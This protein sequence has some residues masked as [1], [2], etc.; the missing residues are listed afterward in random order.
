MRSNSPWPVHPIVFAIYFVLFLYAQNLG[1]VALA[2]VV[3]V[4][5]VAAAAAGLA[6]LVS[7]LIWRDLRRGAL[8]VSVLV[9]IFFGYR[10][11][12]NALTGLPIPTTLQQLGWLALLVGSVV[13]AWRIRD[14]LAGLT[15]ALDLVSGILVLVTLVSIVPHVLG[16]AS[17]APLPASPLPI[18]AGAAQPGPQRDVWYLIFDRYASDRQLGAAYGIEGR[19]ADWLETRGFYVARDSQ[20]NYV[21]TSLSIASS[22]NLTYLDDLAARMGPDSNDHGPV[23]ELMQD[24]VLGRFLQSQ[25]Y[26]FV[27]VGSPYGPTKV[28]AH[29]DQ[30]PRLDSASGFAGAIFDES[31]LPAL[32]RR[33]GL[34]TAT[35]VRERYYETARF[36]QATL[37]GLVEAPG[38]KLVFAHFLLPHPPYVFA[39]DGS[40]VPEED[41]G[42]KVAQEYGRQL[43]YTD[44]MIEA[45]VTRLQ[46][47]PVER[48]PIIVVQA[49]EGPYPDRFAHNTLN[50]DWATATSAEL[51]MKYGILN[52]YDLPGLD[53]TGLYPGITPVNSFR[54]I[55]GRYFGTDTPPLPDREYTSRGKERPYDLTDVTERLAAP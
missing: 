36:Q 10:N 29:A 32:A 25:G 19:L 41:D 48:R 50:F 21:K 54:L 40:F 52:A 37:D 27:Q 30:N 49:D 45:L 26:R 44:T 20:A 6:L 35:P 47:L 22:L 38:P 24:H 42:H 17:A 15:R 43:T 46:A 1:E 5:L 13:A 11:V 23:F 16:Q 28:N 3:P 39:A 18:V 53:Q 4:V 55:L 9:V 51:H 12:A 7:A 14:R 31:V 34:V 33:T 8:I 2:E